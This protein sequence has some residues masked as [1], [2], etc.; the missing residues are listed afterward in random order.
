V[1]GANSAFPTP[2][3]FSSSFILNYNHKLFVLDC[4][5]GAQ[6]KMTEYGIRRSK[7]EHI[8]I[9]H[10][11]GDHI[12]GLPGLLTSFNL[13]GRTNPLSIYGPTGVKPYIEHMVSITG[14]SIAYPIIYQEIE[15]D[16]VVDL[17]VIDGLSIKAVPLVHRIRTYGYV[18]TE[19]HTK[20]NVKSEAITAYSLSIE[21]IKMAQNGQAIRRNGTIISPDKLT[22]GPKPCR[23]FAYCTDTKYEPKIVPHINEVDLLYHEATYLDELKEKAHE[24]MHAT[25]KEAAEIAVMAQAKKLI[26][27]HY[28][29]RYKGLTL[30]LDEAKSVFSNSHLAI[31]GETHQID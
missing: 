16:G 17:G 22:H 14:G 5:E 12:Y 2:D 29:S 4:G 20:R 27:G 1:L 10:L 28:S 18:F 23:S 3:R 31:G 26:I 19:H 15:E 6:I 25:A 8:F 24:R 7:I 30:L 13:N 11:H 21:E 9:T